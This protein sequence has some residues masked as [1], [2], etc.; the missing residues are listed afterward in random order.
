MENG[1]QIKKVREEFEASGGSVLQPTEILKNTNN[2]PIVNTENVVRILRQDSL[3]CGAFRFN[4]FTWEPETRV[5]A[6]RTDADDWSPIMNAEIYEVMRR[7]SREYKGFEKVK[8]SMVREA[9]ISYALETRVNPPADFFRSLMWDGADRVD[10]WLI[11]SFGAPD[12]GLNRAI[13]ANWLKGMMKRAVNPG[14]KFD[15]VLVLEGPQGWKKTTALSTLFSPWF[16]ETYAS[17]NEKDFIMLITSNLVVEFSE[18][19]TLNRS[20]ILQLKSIITRQED[21]YRPPYEPSVVRFPRRCVFVMTTND[22]EYLRD[23]TGNRR[24]LPVELG[25]PANI[26]WLQKNREQLFAEAYHRAI[27]LNETTWEYPQDELEEIQ[28]ERR[29]ESPYEDE[30][31]SW[32]AG[33]TQEQ[34]DDGITTLDAFTS[35]LVKEKGGTMRTLDSM[36]IAGIFSNTLEL[37][38]F[39]KSVDNDRKMRWYDVKHKHDSKES[40]SQDEINIDE[41]KF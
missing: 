14:C 24:W 8:A 2:Q 35:V 26:E 23:M 38:K 33:L 32:Y 29:Q 37:K 40:V 34:R 1:E 16:V 5:L 12:T 21:K 6:S 31:E 3:L 10:R 13:G 27:T 15:E 22:A 19:S 41:I 28:R 7:I 9:I 4:T 11:D 36:M 20:D 30:I 17:P 25:N 39:R 18:G